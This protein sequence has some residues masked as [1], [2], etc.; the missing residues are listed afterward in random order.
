MSPSSGTDI[1]TLRSP[2]FFVQ[3]PTNEMVF[4]PTVDDSQCYLTLKSVGDDGQC[5][6]RKTDQFV[7][8]STSIPDDRNR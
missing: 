5:I 4:H 8:L 1:S 2:I 6:A 7:S 3:E